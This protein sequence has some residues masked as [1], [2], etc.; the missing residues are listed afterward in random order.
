MHTQFL[1]RQLIR[2]VLLTEGV[3]DPG[4]L[5][6]VFM[7]GGPGSGKSYTA[8]EIFG[9][10]PESAIAVA[11]SAGLKLV[12]SDPMFELLLTK[13]GVDLKS[14]ATMSPEEF[15]TVTVGP[16]SP[17][18]KAKK[19]RNKS[20]ALYVQGK[21]GVIIDGTGDDYDKIAKKKHAIEEAGYDAYMIF[22]NTSLSVAQER[23][24]GRP[25]ELPKEMV[26]EIWSHV[27][28]NLGRFQGLFGAQNLTIIDNTRY[29]P[30]S[31]NALAA[32]DSFLNRPIQNP[33]G[34]KWIEAELAA[35]G[36]KD[37]QRKAPGVRDRLLG[38]PEKI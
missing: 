35:R 17:R 18:G 7:A 12:N 34:Q 25:R 24:A 33:I 22:I 21:L 32:V 36:E 11:T 29:G 30:V 31:P 13:A 8:K 5:K 28:E 16:G 38:S 4:V 27:Q 37:I 20:Q 14:L 10:D 23:N 1:L 9:G 2:E 19:L 6:A 3:Y 26:E 15:A